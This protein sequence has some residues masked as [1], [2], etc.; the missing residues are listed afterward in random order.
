MFLH[1]EL[2]KFRLFLFE[3]T[4]KKRPIVRILHSATKYTGEFGVEDHHSKEVVA[5]IRD[6]KERRDPTPVLIQT[7]N[8]TTARKENMAPKDDT[9]TW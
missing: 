9:E 1:W 7:G 8:L 3:F 4:N 6:R 2:G 5:L